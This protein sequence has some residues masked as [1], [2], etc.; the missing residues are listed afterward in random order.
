[1]G[2]S[3]DG[4]R[5]DDCLTGERVISVGSGADRR[6]YGLTYWL[7]N[8]LLSKHAVPDLYGG[9]HLVPYMM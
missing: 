6:G 8:G 5:M 4:S 1:M 2:E 7:S 9:I 3:V